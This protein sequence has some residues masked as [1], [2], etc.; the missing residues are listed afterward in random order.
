MDLCGEMQQN[1]SNHWKEGQACHCFRCFRS[2]SWQSCWKC[3]SNIIVCSR[4]IIYPQN[5]AHSSYLTRSKLTA[6]QGKA[7]SFLAGN[8]AKSN[9]HRQRRRLHQVRADSTQGRGWAKAEACLL[10]SQTFLR[11][12]SFVPGKQPI[13]TTEAEM[14]IKA[15]LRAT[16]ASLANSSPAPRCQSKGGRDGPALRMSEGPAE[17]ETIPVGC[18]NKDISPLS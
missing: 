8:A 10:C 12:G 9:P 1:S 4:E 2:S 17:A 14:P 3:C 16:S 6:W 13:M 18:H 7:P 5:L 11:H 15:V